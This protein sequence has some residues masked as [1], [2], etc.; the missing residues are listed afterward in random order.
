M[1][2]AL[3]F[4]VGEQVEGSSFLFDSNVTVGLPSSTFFTIF[5]VYEV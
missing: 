1:L 2:A 5:F 4:L 3:G